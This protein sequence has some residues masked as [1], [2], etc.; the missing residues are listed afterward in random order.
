MARRSVGLVGGYLVTVVG[1]VVSLL[2][3]ARVLGPVEYGRLAVSLAW[4]ETLQGTLFQWH[5][6]A[7][8]RY[9][10]ANEGADLAA[11]LRTAH[12]VWL[13]IAMVVVLAI[14]VLAVLDQGSA[15]AE[16]CLIGALCLGRSAALYAL[17]IARVAGAAL[18]YAGGAL[19]INLLAAVLGVV[20]FDWTHSVGSVLLTAT[21]VCAV[22]SF[23]CLWGRGPL[24]SRGPPASHLVRTMLRYGAPL[25]P[26]FMASAALTRLDRPI[27]AAFAAPE[28]VGTYAAASALMVN[29]ASAVCL[30]VVTPAYP[31]LLREKE[32]LA[33]EAYRQVHARLNLCTIA[34]VLV[35][36]IAFFGLRATVLPLLLGD[37]IGHGAQ[38]LIAPLLAIAVL[39]V[40]RA[41]VFDQSYHVFS[42][43]R[44]LMVIN[45]CTLALTPAMLYFGA[46]AGALNGLL[47]ALI[48]ANLLALAAS[49][50][51]SR[52]FVGMRTL[53]SGAGMLAVIAALAILGA[54]ASTRLVPLPH[55]ALAPG[56][57]ASMVGAVVFALGVYAA[58]VGSIRSWLKEAR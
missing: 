44:T 11:W 32:R 16:W 43:T 48:A 7:V 2:L 31:W 35:V 20:V 28:V 27:L 26:V 18:R 47:V 24:A 12:L 57:V 19:C 51:F 17:E 56:I 1:G 54:D 29:L 38:D 4:V 40:V 30:V 5:R 10:A 53:V 41:H 42:R 50:W 23:G 34:G 49:A 15:A 52:A 9:W 14:G 45:L 8:V 39:G 36:A 21:L 3:Y 22:A 46:R 13:G 37:A 6:L 55:G 25:I 58:N 33:P